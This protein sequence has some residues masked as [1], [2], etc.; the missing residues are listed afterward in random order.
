VDYISVIKNADRVFIEKFENYQKQSYRNR[1]HILS[2]N[3]VLPLSVPV[4]RS[5][6]RRIDKVCIDYSLQWQ[7]QH[8][9]SIVSAYNSSPFFDFYRDDFVSFYS[10]KFDNLWELNT[11]M[12]FLILELLE[13][14]TELGFTDEYIKNTRLLDLRDAIHPKYS[15]NLLSETEKGQYHQVFA[16]KFEFIPGLSVIDLLFNEG[17]QSALFL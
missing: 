7:H 6:E 12:L 13:I 16:H 1:C 10:K 11:S 8:W 17:P 2:S 9:Q 5:R 4:A 14:N 3:G 15:T